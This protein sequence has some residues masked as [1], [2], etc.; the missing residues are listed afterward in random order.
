MVFDL[1]SVAASI[2]QVAAPISALVLATFTDGLRRQ[3]F[4]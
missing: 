3:V 1:N 4:T 2:V